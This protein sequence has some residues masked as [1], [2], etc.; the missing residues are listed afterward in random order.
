MSVSVMLGLKRRRNLLL[1]SLILLFSPEAF[2]GAN[3]LLILL[4]DFGEKD[5]YTAILKGVIYSIFPGVKIDSIT[6]N[7]DQYDIHQGAYILYEA[8]R[9]FPPGTTFLAMVDPGVGVDRRPIALESL[10]GKYFIGPDNGLFTYVIKYMGIKGIYHIK[11]PSLFRENSTSYTFRGRDLFG[12]VAA[13]IARGTAISEVGPEIKRG[14][15]L[16][17]LKEP[18]VSQGKALGS[19]VHID[20]FGNLLTNLTSEHLRKLPL[21]LGE[22]VEVE[23][24]GRSMRLKF[25]KTYGEMAEG[26][27]LLLIDGQGQVELALNQASLAEALKVKVEAPIVITRLTSENPR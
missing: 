22:E 4:T 23:I 17:N 16:I 20:Q 25:V 10:D 27:P 3:G 6:H 18:H 19:I 13:H 7:I 5:P 9:E 11:N 14:W 12:P 24:E 8:A 2:A 21:E 15:L 1:F 26:S